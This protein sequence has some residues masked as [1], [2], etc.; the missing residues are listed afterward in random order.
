MAIK[1]ILDKMQNYKYIVYN[2]INCKLSTLIVEIYSYILTT[3][4]YSYTLILSLVKC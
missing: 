3:I 4:L 1:R 2:L